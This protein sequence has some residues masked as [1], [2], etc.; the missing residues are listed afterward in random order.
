MAPLSI[1]EPFGPLLPAVCL[2]INSAR[3]SS[4]CVTVYG[5]RSHFNVEP[6]L[7]KELFWRTFFAYALFLCNLTLC[8]NLYDIYTMHCIITLIKDSLFLEMKIICGGHSIIHLHN[9]CVLFFNSGCDYEMF[10]HI[11]GI[12]YTRH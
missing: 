4:R 6:I 11:A 8:P 10:R 2:I 5:G 9:P 1:R 3:S 12:P 7:W